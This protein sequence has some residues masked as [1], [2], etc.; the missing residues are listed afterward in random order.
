[1]SKNSKLSG[2]LVSRN[3]SKERPNLALQKTVI[4]G[5]ESMLQP[6]MNSRSAKTFIAFLGKIR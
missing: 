6:R 4:D 2:K 1:M 5:S 3:T